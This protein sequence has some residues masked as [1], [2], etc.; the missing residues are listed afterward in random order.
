MLTS[1]HCARTRY[2]NTCLCKSLKV[3]PR[4]LVIYRDCDI[5]MV[6]RLIFLDS[7]ENLGP[8]STGHKGGRCSTAMGEVGAN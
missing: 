5:G 1:G 2:H 7:V 6:I 8:V 3:W 4:N